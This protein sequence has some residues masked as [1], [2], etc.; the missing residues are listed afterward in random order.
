[1]ESL[2][3]RKEDVFGQVGMVPEKK[4]IYFQVLFVA[5]T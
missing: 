1:M 2:I 3:G 5:F 4:N